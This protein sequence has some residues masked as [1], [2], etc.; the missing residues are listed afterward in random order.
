MGKTDLILVTK[1]QERALRIYNAILHKTIKLIERYP[2]AEIIIKI[3]PS[4]KRKS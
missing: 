4:K 1:E 2:D 3:N